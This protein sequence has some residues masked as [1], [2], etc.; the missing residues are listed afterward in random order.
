MAALLY[1]W[2]YNSLNTAFDILSFVF[3]IM[4]GVVQIIILATLIFIVFWN[5]F[6][7]IPW[8]REWFDIL[9][10]PFRPNL[11]AQLY[12][13]A[14]LIKMTALLALIVPINDP[15]INIYCHLAIS[16]VSF[17]AL[18][19]AWAF[20]LWSIY[21]FDCLLEFVDLCIVCFY[22]GLIYEDN[23]E[24]YNVWMI[25]MIFFKSL[26]I[27]IWMLFY[28]FFAWKNWWEAR[29]RG[30]RTLNPNVIEQKYYSEKDEHDMNFE[31]IMQ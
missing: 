22:I 10:L 24:S 16:I 12:F 23:G 4:I 20:K 26:F 31:N 28:A 14:Y 9:F 18:I 11:V 7:Q 1:E 8:I 2:W 30:H 6:S 17:I 15:V 29:K 27:F 5:R 13:P 21:I 25:V 19:I 3:S